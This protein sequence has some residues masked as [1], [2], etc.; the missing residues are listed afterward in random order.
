MA[1]K[2]EGQMCSIKEQIIEDPASGLTLQFAR[3]ESDD[4]PVRLKIFGYDHFSS[5]EILFDA[6][7]REV[8]AGTSF[9]ASKFTG[10]LQ[11]V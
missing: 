6:N 9:G 2:P 11:E 3:V 4:A 7:G 1:L 5:R 8:G 10:W